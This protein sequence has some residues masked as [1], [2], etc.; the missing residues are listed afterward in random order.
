MRIVKKK[1]V[2]VSELIECIPNF[3]EARRPEVVQAIVE[4]ITTVPGVRVLDVSSDLDHNRTVV[5]FVGDSAAV[6]AGAFAG[7]AKAAELID[8][9]QHTGAHPRIGATDV[10]PFVPIRHA[11]LEDC[12]TLA[13][14]LGERVGRELKIPVYLYE[15]A[16]TRPERQNL[17]NLRRGQYEGLKHEIGSNP[18]R[19]PDFGPLRLG[20][21][22]ATVIGA[23]PFLIAYNVYLN[24]PD[25]D[26]AKKVAR[27]VR[28]SS[29]G[30][31]YVKA[32]GLLVAGRAQ[33]SM[34]LTDFVKTPM[35]RV[36]EMIRRE[37][38]R[39][40]IHI[41][42]SEVI[43]LI[44]QTALTDA[45][46]WYLQLDGLRKEQILEHK[47]A[48]LEQQ[49][50]AAASNTAFLDS[51]AAGTATPGGGAAAAYSGAMAAA[52]VTMVARLTIGK[53]RYAEIV[54]QME[55]V[56]SEAE[57]LRAVLTASVAA[58]C[59]AFDAV[60]DAYKRPQDSDAERAT[61]ATAIE[62][63]LH[64]ATAVPLQ[65]ARDASR[66][67]ELAASVAEKGNLNAVGEAGSAANLALAAVHTAA[68][69]VRI[70][71]AAVKNREGAQQCLGEIAALEDKASA[72]AETIGLIVRNRL[73][74]GT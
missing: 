15:A 42:N 68:L 43:G 57:K 49:P 11:A 7:L 64:G 48:L 45:A 20:K 30:L 37:A 62:Q 70:N 34:N 32:L 35:P 13:R 51:L 61:R 47:L 28:H 3:S 66:V 14:R 21:A 26:I 1:G 63:A 6:E 54:S 52:L 69:N 10:V 22:G 39:Y 65:V 31:R 33:V 25:V 9:D 73:V 41:V 67:L 19:Q 24:T 71:A 23:R 8:L 18:D 5:T 50:S 53:K 29:G 36:V 44:P 12:V 59:A 27:A 58:D 17:E 16:A 55:E 74:P 38:A 56:Q 2:A 60:M 46:Q 4:A 72:M 40:G